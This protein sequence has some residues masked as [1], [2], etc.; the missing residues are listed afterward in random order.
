MTHTRCDVRPTVTF[1]AKDID[2]VQD[3]NIVQLFDGICSCKLYADD[4]K[5]YFVSN[6]NSDSLVMQNASVTGHVTA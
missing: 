2:V 5:L 1:P 4:L 3:S 6:T